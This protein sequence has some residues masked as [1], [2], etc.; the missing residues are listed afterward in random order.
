MARQFTRARFRE[1]ALLLL[2]GHDK[3]SLLGEV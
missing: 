1:R 2:Q 3:T